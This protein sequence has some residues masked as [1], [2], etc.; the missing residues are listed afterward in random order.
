MA[1][2][3]AKKSLLELWFYKISHQELNLSFL[4]RQQNK[5]WE[6]GNFWWGF[7]DFLGGFK[8]A[9]WAKAFSEM[10]KNNQIC[11]HKQGGG[12]SALPRGKIGY[13]GQPKASLEMCSLLPPAD[14]LLQVTAGWFSSVHC[15]WFVFHAVIFADSLMIKGNKQEKTLKAW[16]K[17]W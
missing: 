15:G 10:R 2:I 13:L 5:H 6:G 4:N 16:R 7:V 1:L 9:I 8:S 3:T 11:G 12:D 17:Q 14:V